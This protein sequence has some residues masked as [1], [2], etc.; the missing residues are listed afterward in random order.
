MDVY[1]SKGLPCSLAPGKFSVHTT[2]A[3]VAAGV[4]IS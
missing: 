3:E 2:I 1:V 4:V